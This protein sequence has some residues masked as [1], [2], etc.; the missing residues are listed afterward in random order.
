MFHIEKVSVWSD[1]SALNEWDC[2]VFTDPPLLYNTTH[3]Y[4]TKRR[5]NHET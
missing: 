5:Q 3:N 2:V 1:P 4:I